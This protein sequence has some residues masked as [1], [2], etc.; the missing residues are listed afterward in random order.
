MKP[1]TLKKILQISAWLFHY[2]QS[3]FILLS[4]TSLQSCDDVAVCL[5]FGAARVRLLWANLSGE[6]FLPHCWEICVS[7]CRGCREFTD[8]AQSDGSSWGSCRF[9]YEPGTLGGKTLD[10]VALSR[11]FVSSLLLFPFFLKTQV[12]RGGD[13]LQTLLFSERNEKRF[14]L[15]R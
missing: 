13:S 11:F 7:R 14:R 5:L 15:V 9:L 8:L 12:S 2:S 6:E 4:L 10:E 1:A 3:V